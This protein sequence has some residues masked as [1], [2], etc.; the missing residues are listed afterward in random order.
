MIFSTLT[1]KY[2]ISSFVE[3]LLK[4]VTNDWLNC[5]AKSLREQTISYGI[6]QILFHPTEVRYQPKL[7]KI[8]KFLETCIV[9]SSTKYH[10]FLMYRTKVI[11]KRTMVNDFPAQLTVYIHPKTLRFLALFWMGR[12]SRICWL[13]KNYSLE[14]V[15][16][17]TQKTFFSRL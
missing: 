2:V 14:K 12:V 6:S 3:Y 5:V 9:N 17:Y 11:G 8:F 16:I 15:D 13:W 1:I 10:C 4:S 7:M